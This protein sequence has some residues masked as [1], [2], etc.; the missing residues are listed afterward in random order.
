LSLWNGHN[1]IVLESKGFRKLK[2]TSSVSSLGF[3]MLHLLVQFWFECRRF[4]VTLL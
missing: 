4:G 2:Q 3:L 1:Y